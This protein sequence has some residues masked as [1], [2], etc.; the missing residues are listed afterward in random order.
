MNNYRNHRP[1]ILGYLFRFVIGSSLILTAGALVFTAPVTLI[2]L[3][4]G[5]ILLG[6][7]LEMMA[8]GTRAPRRTAG[9]VGQRADQRPKAA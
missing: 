6:A 4:L 9:N 5:V 3:P 8:G 2:G 1:S 7:G